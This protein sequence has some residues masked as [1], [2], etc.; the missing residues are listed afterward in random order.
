M[1]NV[2]EKPEIARRRGG[3]PAGAPD[4]EL[5]DTVVA[6]TAEQLKA[7]GDQTRLAILDL[8]LDRAAT[9]TELARALAKPKGTIDHHLKVLEAAG[10][11]QVVRTRRV[12]AVT[13]R[14]WGRTGRTI[15]F[16]GLPA[17]TP[18]ARRKAFMVGAG[19]EEL[20][21]LPEAIQGA[22]FST[23]R[24][25]RIAR[26]RAD[27]FAARLEELAVEFASAPRGGETVYGLLLAVYPTDRPTLPPPGNEA[28]R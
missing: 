22:S 14:F 25:A 12:R 16:H 17:N 21:A 20:M 5:A 10:L 15:E 13:E 19:Y 1:P 2:R 3:R 28:G 11:A 9:T 7:L 24:H 23:F 4:Y 18:P 26:E 8:V 6:G 27:E